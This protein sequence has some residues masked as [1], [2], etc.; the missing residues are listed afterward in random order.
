MYPSVP[1]VND[2]P[3]AYGYGNN[4]TAAPQYPAAGA[5]GASNLASAS[6]L[7]ASPWGT[8]SSSILRVKIAEDYK[9][10]APVRAKQLCLQLV[11]LVSGKPHPHNCC[12]HCCRCLC[13][14]LWQL[15][16][17]RSRNLTMSMNARSCPTTHPRRLTLSWPSQRCVGIVQPSQ[18]SRHSSRDIRVDAFTSINHTACTTR[19]YHTAC[20]TPAPRL[21][22]R[23][24]P[25]NLCCADCLL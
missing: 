5:G 20:T 12:C 14:Q 4:I 2:P 24:V 1:G 22:Q 13:P 25:H 10:D 16:A 9:L 11:L 7:D 23:R 17:N 19:L 18:L 3:R 8:D 6:S 15:A 21:S